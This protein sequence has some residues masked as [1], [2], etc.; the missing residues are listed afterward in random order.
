M[1]KAL[2]EEEKQEI[3]AK[4]AS[5]SAS[6][7]EALNKSHQ[8]EVQ[9]ELARLLEITT[10]IN[11]TDK[12]ALCWLR[13]V[14]I[15]LCA[16]CSETPQFHLAKRVRIDLRN[17]LSKNPIIAMLTGGKERAHVV[18]GLI[19]F[20]ALCIILSW[21]YLVFTNNS[22]Q[23]YVI[24]GFKLSALVAIAFV[25]ALGSIVSI[26]VELISL[27]PLKTDDQVL[28]FFTGF[29][30]PIVGMSFAL[31]AMA[32]LKSK[33]IPLNVPVNDAFCFLISF[34]AGYSE[35]F[36]IGLVGKVVEEPK[37]GLQPPQPPANTSEV[38]HA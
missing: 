3:L 4:L 34:V 6:I 13:C 27:Q 7:K 16:L 32:A 28:L 26:M 10:K 19:I 12:K 38:P 21:P 29:L 1:E 18:F 37:S 22:S 31:F 36:A 33:I 25:G 24:F 14:E 9:E 35:R 5:I 17:Q 23:E 30:K 8:K 15:A 2:S 20:I 11:E